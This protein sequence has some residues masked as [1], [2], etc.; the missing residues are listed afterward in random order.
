MP[1]APIAFTP[2]ELADQL[3]AERGGRPFLVLRDGDGR[4][5]L[6]ELV[7]DRLAVGRDPESDLKLAW[8]SNV[9]R[10]HAVLERLAGS[11]TVAD[12]ELSTNGTFLNE[13]RVRGR[14][15]LHDRDVLRFG[16]TRAIYRDPAAQADE[17]PRISGGPAAGA[18][19]PAQRRVLVALCGPLLEARGPVNAPPSNREI[20]DAVNLSVES[21]R[22]HLKTLFRIFE[23][24][25]LPQNRKRAELARRALTAGVITPR[26]LEG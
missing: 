14:R 15:R 8:D 12:E 10:L 20:A 18:V 3:A 23:I 13:A 2:G 21:V 11:W 4:Q 6:R 1:S 17:T 19:S 26:D 7:G 16:D 9:S 22:S 5:V 24:P 25:A